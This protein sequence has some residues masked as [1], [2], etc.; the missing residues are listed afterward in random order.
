MTQKIA[1]TPVAGIGQLF[2][3]KGR[4]VQDFCYTHTGWHYIDQHNKHKTPQ[5]LVN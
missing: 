5:G 1:S 2:S 4:V 3:F